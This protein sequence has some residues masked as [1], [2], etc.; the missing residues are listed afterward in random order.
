MSDEEKARGPKP[1]GGGDDRGGRDRDRGGR[2]RDRDR[3][4]ARRRRRRKGRPDIEKMSYVDFK[5]VRLLRQFLNDRGCIVP[6]RQTGLS[7]RAQ[8]MLTMAIKRAREMALLPFV[9]EE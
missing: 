6:R 8:R 3:D 7:A 2:D 4:R 5:D 9:V 1:G